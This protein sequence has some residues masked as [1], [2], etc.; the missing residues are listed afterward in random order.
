DGRSSGWLESPDHCGLVQWNPGVE[1][2]HMGDGRFGYHGVGSAAFGTEEEQGTNQ[3]LDGSFEW[4]QLA[5][6][7]FDAEKDHGEDQAE[8]QAEDGNL[9]PYGLGLGDANLSSWESGGDQMEPEISKE[10]MLAPTELTPSSIIPSSTLTTEDTSPLTD[11][12][13]AVRDDEG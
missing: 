3:I 12:N 8:D 7:G 2:D 11:V 10:T 6:A 1:E 5:T 4:Y 13:P 9:D